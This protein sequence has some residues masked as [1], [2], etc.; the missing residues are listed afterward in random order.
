MELDLVDAI[1]EAIVGVELGWVGVGL[2]APLD[3]L[4]GAA[5]PAE[6]AHHV[7][8]PRAALALERLA[9]R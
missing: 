9:Q 3:R 7:V 2:K 6:L 8:R 1:A 4:F 5:Q